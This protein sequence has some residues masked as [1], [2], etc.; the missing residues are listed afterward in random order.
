[1]SGESLAATP[2]LSPSPGA[3]ESIPTRHSLPVDSSLPLLPYGR[4]TNRLRISSETDMP[5]C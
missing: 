1:M 3:C 4:R 5:R 2:R